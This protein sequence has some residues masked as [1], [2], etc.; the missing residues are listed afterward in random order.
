MDEDTIFNNKSSFL[1]SWYK[2]RK[3]FE[4]F[5]R[6][7][8]TDLAINP[9]EIMFISEVYYNEGTSQREIAKNLYV[10]E[11]NIA[12]T[13]K[14]LEEKGLIYKTIDKSNNTRRQLYLTEKGEDFFK[15]TIKLYKEF[16]TY[17]FEGYT[18][19]EIA[20]M[21]KIMREISDKSIDFV[22]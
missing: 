8:S 18:E 7:A 17:I 21:K 11:A 6:D 9:A 22:N 16:Q 10:S 19:E 2:F 14:K 5:F 20:T 4:K 3:S 13:F 1:I 12:K 15:D